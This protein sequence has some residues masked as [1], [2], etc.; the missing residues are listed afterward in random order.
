MFDPI[1]YPKMNCGRN[2]LLISVCWIVHVINYLL[3]GT[4]V[5]WSIVIW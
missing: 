2:L 1:S 4:S 3:P 5:L